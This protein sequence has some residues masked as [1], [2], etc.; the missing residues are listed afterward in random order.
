MCAYPPERIVCLAEKTVETLHRLGEDWRIAGVPRT[1]T[2]TH[3][4]HA[5]KAVI[6]DFTRPLKGHSMIAPPPPAQSQTPSAEEI[7]LA[8]LF[9]LPDGADPADAACEELRRSQLCRPSDPRLARLAALLREVAEEA[10]A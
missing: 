2:R 4:S 1:T 9:W 10:H 5:G 3:R 6:C 7:L 8:W